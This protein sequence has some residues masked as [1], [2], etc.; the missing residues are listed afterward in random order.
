MRVIV[1]R[2]KDAT[3]ASSMQDMGKLMA[4]VM[5]ELKGKADGGIV[6]KI[7]REELS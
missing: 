2:A 5:P 4:A 7:V 6:S 1:K 3:G